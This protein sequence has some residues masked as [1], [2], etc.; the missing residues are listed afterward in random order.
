[1]S[2]SPF[3]PGSV[4]FKPYLHDELAIADRLKELLGQAV[5]AEQAGFDGFVLSEHHAKVLPGYQPIPTTI[6]GWVLAQT[7]SIWAAPCPTLL[8]LRPTLLV[9]E[10]LAWLAAAF[11]DRVGAGFAAGWSEKEFALV[12]QSAEDLAGRFERAL[13]RAA[14][15]LRGDIS[16]GWEDDAVERLSRH[17]VPV[18]SAVSSRVA[19]RRA[20]RLGVGILLPS[21]LT[22][23]STR[24]FVD[25]YVAAG[26]QGPLVVNRRVWVGDPPDDM[27]ARQLAGYRQ[28]TGEDDETALSGDPRE[29]AD[30]LAHFLQLSG[31]QCA[32][33]RIHLHGTTTGEARS[34]LEKIGADLLPALRSNSPRPT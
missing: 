27:P 1:V 14:L 9:A 7:N 30:Q 17:P 3:S 8:L 11:P 32:I 31:T 2:T 18:V 23:E 28:P 24:R 20:A 25:E 19:C 34:Q 4:A 29:V 10:E 13:E 33:L 12:E 16:G 22:I 15:T 5:L 26:G 6:V 21:H